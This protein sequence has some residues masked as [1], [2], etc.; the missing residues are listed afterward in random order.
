M[1]GSP[2][3]TKHLLG[4]NIAFLLGQIKPQLSLHQGVARRAAALHGELCGPVDVPRQQLD[5][6]SEP[7]ID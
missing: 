4:A 3:Y 7:H 6:D 5:G 2:L 1:Q